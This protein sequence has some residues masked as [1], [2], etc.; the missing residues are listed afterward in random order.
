MFA[1]R[2]VYFVL[3][4]W[5]ANPRKQKHQRKKEEKKTNTKKGKT[6]TNV[7]KLYMETKKH[8]NTI[9]LVQTFVFF[10]RSSPSVVLVA[11]AAGRDVCWKFP[12]S[13]FG[14]TRPFWKPGGGLVA[15]VWGA[16]IFFVMFLVVLSWGFLVFGGV[17]GGGLNKH[18]NCN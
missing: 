15:N 6:K 18:C 17:I 5:K 9:K 12:P 3:G 1:K 8:N 16:S 13:P 7:E 4:F 2:F 11:S 10:S 14:R